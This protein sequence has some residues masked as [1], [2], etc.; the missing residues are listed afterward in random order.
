MRNLS[1]HRCFCFFL[2]RIYQF[3]FLRRIFLNFRWGIF[4]FQSSFLLFCFFDIAIS[5]F[6][7]FFCVPVSIFLLCFAIAI[8]FWLSRFVLR[9][10]G[11]RFRDWFFLHFFL[12]DWFSDGFSIV[13]V[14]LMLLCEATMS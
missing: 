11:L 9:C 7:S 3:L 10:G 14:I 5:F 2:V 8:Y 4:T 12:F 1:F 13:L 6:F